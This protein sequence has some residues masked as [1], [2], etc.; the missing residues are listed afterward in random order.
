MK[1]TSEIV[2]Y[3]LNSTFDSVFF[4]IFIVILIFAGVV[5]LNIGLWLFNVDSIT[6]EMTKWSII[7]GGVVGFILAL[8]RSPSKR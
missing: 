7:L 8:F 3:G 1:E 6:P 5:L 2:K 4:L